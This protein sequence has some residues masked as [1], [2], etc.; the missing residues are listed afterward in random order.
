[1]N[2]STDDRTIQIYEAARI[3]RERLGI[4]D[5]SNQDLIFLIEKNGVF[6]FE[7]SLDTEFDAYSL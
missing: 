6:I 2:H 4:G 5:R 7:K 3:A 1:M